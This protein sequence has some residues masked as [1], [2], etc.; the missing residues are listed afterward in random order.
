MCQQLITV[1]RSRSLPLWMKM[2]YKM[3]NATELVAALTGVRLFNTVLIKVC[4]VTD[5]EYVY[6]GATGKAFKWRSQGWV[7]S[8]GPLSDVSLWVDLLELIDEMGP[9]AQ[10]L[11][12]LSHVG[13]EGSEVATGVAIEGMC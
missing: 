12:A 5:S 7:G 6:L 9:M 2:R 4:I 1:R 8:K 10:W 11:W 3:N 13:L